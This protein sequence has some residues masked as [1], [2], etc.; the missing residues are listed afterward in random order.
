MPVIGHAVPATTLGLPR[1]NGIVYGGSVKPSKRGRSVRSS[2]Y[3]RWV[4]RR[5]SPSR[6]S[7]FGSIM[8]KCDLATVARKDS[9]E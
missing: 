1:K 3:R 2:R 5:Q 4:D 8:H 6:V 9:K 7:D